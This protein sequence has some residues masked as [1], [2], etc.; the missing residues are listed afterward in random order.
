MPTSKVFSGVIWAS[1]QRFGTMIISF[2]T[3]IVLARLLTPDDFGTIG[4]LLLFLAIANTFV[5]SGFGSALI[6]KKDADQTDFSTVFFINLGLSFVVYAIL[7]FG[8]PWVA[9]FYDVEILNPLLRV[10]GLILIIQ[11]FSIIQTS[12]LRKRM[13]FKRL[14]VCNLIGNIVGS[15]LGIVAALMG[16]GVWSLVIRTLV[17]GAVTTLL[18]WIVS[19]WRPI[20][21]FSKQS[22]KE[23]FG[24]GGFML[25]SSLVYSFS[26]NIQSLVIGK[27]FKPSDLGNY[28]QAKQLRNIATD[29]ASS[30]ISQVLF[31]EFSNNQGDNTVLS[32]KLNLSVSIIS[33]LTVGLMALLIIVAKPLVLLLYGSQWVDSVLI[34]QWLCSAGCFYALQDV[35][36]NLTIAKGYSKIIFICNAISVMLYILAMYIGARLNGVIGLVIASV[37]YSIVLYFFFSAL[38]SY[39]LKEKPIRQY[40]LILKSILSVIIPSFLTIIINKYLLNNALNVIVVIVDTIVLFSSYWIICMK[41]RN[42]GCLYINSKMRELLSFKKVIKNNN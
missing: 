21:C 38:A 31:P 13:D 5:D 19:H 10:Q 29:S 9:N 25:L 23:L 42:A 34:F 4:M 12:L 6:Q 18:L 41:T 32:N 33:F 14:S 3:N 27:L 7:F 15:V 11:A 36:I 8:A 37:I 26:N 30:V 1:V 24:F 2:V 39:F 16:Y 17:V 40:T 28:T 20:A 22:F 35:N